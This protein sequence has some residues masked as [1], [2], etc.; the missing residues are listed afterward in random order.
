[1]VV[2]RDGASSIGIS[3]FFEQ[4]GRAMPAATRAIRGRLRRDIDSLF[5]NKAGVERRYRCWHRPGKRQNQGINPGFLWTPRNRAQLN[6]IQSWNRQVRKPI[7]R[8]EQESL[9]RVQQ[10]IHDRRKAGV[11]AGRYRY[12]HDP[13]DWTSRRR[14]AASAGYLLEFRQYFELHTGLGRPAAGRTVW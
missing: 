7:S 3:L 8:F 9:T 1:M 10:G 12:G 14:Q 13:D 11:P 4:P 6:R 5:A 2:I